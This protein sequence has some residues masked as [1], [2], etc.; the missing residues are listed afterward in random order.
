MGNLKII[1]G[2]FLFSLLVT[3]CSVTVPA[4][5]P[6]ITDLK[7]ETKS[8]IE[9][10]I[11]ENTC[12]NDSLIEL[13]IDLD[14]DNCYYI[15]SVKNK[16]DYKI[17]ILW[18]EAVIITNGNQSTIIHNGTKFI[19]KDKTQLPTVILGNTL[20]Q[21]YFTVSN[22]VYWQTGRY[23]QWIVPEVV[24]STDDKIVVSIPIVI[25]DTTYTYTSNLIIKENGTRKVPN[26]G[27]ILAGGVLGGV[28]LGLL[29]YL[30][31]LGI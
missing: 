28:G 16:S 19:D 5:S 2:L 11:V 31:I 25:N 18:D 6:L 8:N 12:Y 1:F 9:K 10:F 7:K 14:K 4:Y 17:K 13:C 24:K 15:L 3:S 26:V 30:F 29:L 21:E 27:G 20:I 22:N 23:A